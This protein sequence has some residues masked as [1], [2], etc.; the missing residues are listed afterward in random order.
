MTWNRDWPT[1]I[2]GMG[3]SMPMAVITLENGGAP[4]LCRYTIEIGGVPNQLVRE[5]VA[6]PLF[7]VD[8]ALAAQLAAG[9]AVPAA[10]RAQFAK[11]GLPLSARAIL[12]GDAGSWRIQDDGRE[13]EYALAAAPGAFHVFDGGESYQLANY[14]FWK[15]IYYPRYERWEVT[16]ETGQITSYGGGVADTADPYRYRT[17]A[18]NSIEWAVQ[19]CDQSGHALWMGNSAL[20]TGQQQCARAWHIARAYSQFGDSISYGYNEFARAGGL[21]PGV[22]QL[23]GHQGRPYTK[24]CY[25]TSITDV[26]GRKA[27]FTYA[28]KLWG[29]AQASPREYTDPHKEVPDNEPNGFQD[30]YETRY[31]DHIAVQDVD[32]K[33]LFSL[34]FAYIVANVAGSS[35]DTCKR[36]LT[37]FEMR[38]PAQASLPG[39]LFAYHLEGGQGS[40]PGALKTITWPT[41]GCA[42][43]AYQEAKLDICERTAKVLPPA[44]MADATPRVWFGPDYAVVLWCNGPGGQLSLQILGWNGQWQPWQPDENALLAND[45]KRGIDLI[46]LTVLTSDNFVAILF[47]QSPNTNLHLFRKDPARPARWI[48]ASIPNDPS[49][50]TGGC[51]SPTLRWKQNGGAVSGLVGQ[52]FLLL[53]QMAPAGNTGRYDVLTWNWPSQSWT[54]ST[55]AIDKFMLFGGGAEYYASVTLGKDS[56]IVLHH[57]APTGEWKDSR[58]DVPLGSGAPG[59]FA[60]ACG[61][62][63]LALSHKTGSGSTSHTYEVSLINWN[64][65]YGMSAATPFRFED[66]FNKD[67]PTSWAPVIVS[68]ALVAVAG[69]L[70]RFNGQKWLKNPKLSPTRSQMDLQQRYAY[71][72]DFGVLLNT[73]VNG[74]GVV[75]GGAQLLAYD[76]NGAAAEW[77]ASAQAIDLPRSSKEI[78]CWASAGNPDYLTVGTWLF[79]RGTASDWSKAIS[80]PW[81]ADL[82]NVIN[83]G[84]ST[85]GYKAKTQSVVNQGPQFLCLAADIVDKANGSACFALPLRNGG[86]PGALASQMLEDQRMWTFRAGDGHGPGTYPGGDS[87]FFTY[88]ANKPLDKPGR[89]FL[90]RYAGDAIQGLVSHWPVSTV[91][92]DDGLSESSI[93]TYVPDPKTA[94]CDASGNVVKYF[95]STVYPGSDQDNRANGSVQNTYLNGNKI[96]DGTDFFNVLDG[97]LASSTISDRQG[98]ALLETRNEWTVYTRRAGDPCDGRAAPLQLYGAYVLK[99]GQK[100]VRDGVPS[101]QSTSYVPKGLEYPYTGQPAMSRADIMNGGGQQETDVL[102][103]TYACEVDQA[104]RVLNRLTTPAGKT[105]SNAGVTTSASATTLTGWSTLWGDDVLTPA[106]EASF[107]WTGGASVFP[108][109]GCQPGQTPPNWQCVTRILQRDQHGNVIEHV[110]GAG[111]RQ[112]A[113]MSEK[114]GFPVATFNGAALAECAW[115]NFQD[116][117]DYEKHSGWDIRGATLCT[118]NAWL[119]AQ[120]LR[121]PPGASLGVTV[122]PPADRTAYLLGFRYQTQGGYNPADSGWTAKLGGGQGVA[123]FADTQGQWRYVTAP[124]A[125]PAGTA[126]LELRAHNGGSGDVLLD[127]VL[128]VPFGTDVTTQS[129]R[130]AERLLRASMNTA[131]NASFNLYDNFWRPLGAVGGDGQLQELNARFLARQ[132]SPDGQPGNDSPNAELTLH[133]G[134]G[135]VAETFIDGGKWRGR[136]QPGDNALWKAHGGVLSKASAIPDNL[137]WRGTVRAGPGI[138][139]FVETSRPT[140]FGGPVAIR[141]GAGQA[142]AWTPGSGWSWTGTGGASLQ[143][144]LAA[145]PA[146][147]SQWL[148]VLAANHL[149]FFGDG[150]LLFSR[151]AAVTAAQGFAFSTGPN[152]LQINNLGYGLDPRLGLSYLDGAA[153]QRQVHQ[154]R[155]G[156][157][158]VMEIVYDALDRTIAQTRAAPGSFG[159]GANVPPLRYR[160]TFLDIPAFLASLKN[161]CAMRGDVAAYYAGQS[162]AGVPRSNDQNYPYSGRRY[163]GAPLQR[164]TESGQPGLELSIHDVD[165]TAAAQRKTTRTAYAA[166]GQDEGLPAGKYSAQT[167]TT[168]SGCQGRVLA[169]TASRAVLAMQMDDKGGNVARTQVKPGYSEGVGSGGVAGT[170]GAMRLPNAYGGGP[171]AAAFVRTYLQDPL[172]QPSAF[173]DPD[174]GATT[175]LFNGK[176]KARFVKVALE[177]DECHFLYVKYDALGRTVEEGLVR[178][179]WN[180]ATL[181]AQADNLAYPAPADGAV[182]A[183]FYQYDGDGS[184]PNDI[185]KLTQAVTFNPAPASHPGLGACKV[186]ERWSYDALGRVRTASMEVSGAASLNAGATYHYNNLNE[187]VQIDLPAG[188]PLANVVYAYNDQGQIASIGVAGAPEAIA[189]YKWSADGQLAAATRGALAETWAY[190]SP[191]NMSRHQVAAGGQT[192]FAQSFSYTPDGQ[193][194]RRDTTHGAGGGG[195]DRAGQYRYDGQQ[196]LAAATMADG[197]PGSLAISKYDLNGNILAGVQDGNSF[198]AACCLGTNRLK[199]ATLAGSQANAF[200]YRNDGRPDLWRGMKLEYDLALGMT[201]AAGN[202]SALVRYA[203]GLDNHLVLRQSG[204]ALSINFLGAGGMP[205]VIWTDGKPQVCVW[206]PGGLVAAHDGVLRYPISDHQNTIWA[207]SDAQGHVV[208]SYDYQPF[209]AI[210]SQNGSA[211]G[212]WPF[213]YAGKTWDAETGLYDFGTRLYDPALMRFLQPDPARQYASAY[214]FVNNNPLNLIDPDGNQSLWAQVGIDIA[215]AVVVIA[216]VALA[217]E[218]GGASEIAVIGEERALWVELDDESR[219]IYR[220]MMAKAV[221]KS[222]ARSV[223]S[224]ALIGAGTSGMAYDTSH[225]RDFTW[226]AFGQA[227]FSGAVTGAVAGGLEPGA[228]GFSDSIKALGNGKG[229]F[230]RAG[231][232]GGGMVVG[233]V[234]STALTDAVYQQSHTLQDYGIR[235]AHAFATGALLGAFFGLSAISPAEAAVGANTPLIVRTSTY[236]NRLKQGLKWSNAR[237]GY[238][239]TGGVVVGVYGVWGLAERSELRK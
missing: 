64:S 158:V 185:G 177:P 10:L 5:T 56:S 237:C 87:A 12:T 233:S 89:V 114:L 105:M 198:T 66:H 74:G 141:F 88:P 138:A 202:G 55:T 147:A 98:A 142:I 32:G 49:L 69:N 11:R 134:N 17:S 121:L 26:F 6:A 166:N 83:Q 192:L 97:L 84:T 72:P 90:H 217:P 39:F 60:L 162:E 149:L 212:S 207:V 42:T 54:R 35:G 76:A 175:S 29:A 196:Q 160:D 24:A 93:N 43:Y 41:G 46:S 153:R 228:M 235:S 135:G 70:M 104:S 47:D 152:A 164:V 143:K 132:G 116:Y 61:A 78:D 129:W 215:M 1:G 155:D 182:A 133:M 203:R 226:K 183:R 136:W 68:G 156:D 57:L 213:Q 52:N 239:K 128:L 180:L 176:G 51:N 167:T 31:L 195:A 190:D 214:V 209:G 18:G 117:E 91:T 77:T 21:L 106:E 146:M 95:K 37:G 216:G 165:T 7:E 14:R 124:V 179:P 200:H 62:S 19:W 186:Q 219:A 94:G 145:P 86:M 125:I 75:D 53:A 223:G 234:V 211:T 80:K 48:A 8:P 44:G 73:R 220:K 201:S 92:I 20:A 110:D 193:I 131:G 9:H 119:G 208:A 81:I 224:G 112:S 122:K 71:G 150:Q 123:A 65:E 169:D 4:T 13:R 154:F 151:A 102:R 232:G 15:V 67:H 172:G 33:P 137:T 161:T 99:T 171:D 107:G 236:I 82:S 109:A 188:S 36:L 130:Q 58:R 27:L 63:L 173:A 30:R 118:D 184:D 101:G 170:S 2:L 23:V 205:L 127:S 221:A 168:P 79:F 103:Y 16:S 50:G 181:A 96:D 178:R 45:P 225:G 111:T 139:F 85:S 113:L 191:G 28:P 157:S 206:G 194:A 197:Q 115:N 22:E 218:T 210:A 163:G 100:M 238:V 120:S 174:T 3:W 199:S 140:A 25:L 222:I 108:R 148:L 144:A 40:N 34:Q 159:S 227:V 231:L 229:I 38:N 189:R 230:V 59:D 187:I 126:S 204:G